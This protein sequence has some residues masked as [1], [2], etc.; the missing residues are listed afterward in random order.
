MIIDKDAAA[1]LE[2]WL[3]AGPKSWFARDDDF[4][5]AM[6]NR[7]AS[8]HEEAS[9]GQHDDWADSPDG[10]LALVLVLDQFSR[11]L[12]RDDARAFAQDGHAL[13]IAKDALDRGFD[14]KV[15][16]AVFV[17]FYMPY[18]HSESILDQRSCIRLFH[19]A[20][21]SDNMTYAII[22]HH[23]IARFGHFPHRNQAIGRPTS[24]AEQ[25]F[26][27]DGGFSA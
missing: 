4:D 8:L 10:A 27:D 24:P 25:R 22:H 19:A 17:F 9:Q 21:K 16:P 18:M 13:K 6:R 11:N 3:Q 5:A 7:F 1:V 23:V 26:L 2:F 12:F 14:K 20:N 15:D